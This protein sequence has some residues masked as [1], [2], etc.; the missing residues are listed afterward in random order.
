MN[1][2]ELINLVYWI[3]LEIVDMGVRQKYQEL[4]GIIQQNAQQNQ[5]QQSFESQ[6][7]DLI[8]T[9][10]NVPLSQLGK[11]QAKFLDSLGI[12]EAVGHIGVKE[13]E[14]ILYRNVIDSATAANKLTNI[15]QKIVEGIQ[16]AELIQHGLRDYV[17]EEAY[18]L[19]N[20]VLI[21][22]SFTGKAEMANIS[23]LKKWSSLW[24]EIGR[25]VTMA[26]DASAD[27]IKVI[28]A[29]RGS[30]VIELAVIAS[31][32]TTISGIIFAALQVADKV[33]DLLKKA[34]EIRNL[35]LQNSRLANTIEQEA[36][37]EKDIGI[38]RIS[39]NM[40]MELG[41][42]K[43]GEGDKIAALTKAVKNLVTFIESGG[44]ID[45]VIPENIGE[46]ENGD[47]NDERKPDFDKLR[48]TFSEIRHLENK[49]QLLESKVNNG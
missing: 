19:E 10:Q 47:D 11:D 12:G 45:F 13:V 42:N 18:E 1:V 21:R 22:V 49:I 38:A 37:N 30:V 40:S 24:Y 25:G 4:F 46:A 8:L 36:K 31:F 14:D 23:D 28:G 43:D 44:D 9:L 17:V 15:H 39:E 5:Q 20:E 26:H 29:T 32:A 7:E 3:Q 48:V 16:R 34:E 27:E 35:K 33:L 6:K 2:S 41:L